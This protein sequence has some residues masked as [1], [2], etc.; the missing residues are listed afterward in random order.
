[1]N[2]EGNELHDEFFYFFES[3]A[4]NE[5]FGMPFAL[6]LGLVRETKMKERS[7]F[8][9]LIDWWEVYFLQ[10]Q[11]QYQQQ[12]REKEQEENSHGILIYRLSYG[13]CTNF[14]FSS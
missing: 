13:T 7:G 10:Q 12:L 8:H 6:S 14:C 11:Q 4:F 9:Y 3:N 1:M 2:K 5:L